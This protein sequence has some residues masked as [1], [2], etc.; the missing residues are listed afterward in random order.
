MVLNNLTH[1][2]LRYKANVLTQI[3]KQVGN[4][5]HDDDGYNN[6]NGKLTIAK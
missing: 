6:N 3:Y 2:P 5:N 1:V 4:N